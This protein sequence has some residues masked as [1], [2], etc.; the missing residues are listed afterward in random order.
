MIIWTAFR[1]NHSILKKLRIQLSL[2][3][4]VQ[5]RIM[6][7]FG[8]ISRNEDS[9]ERVVVQGLALMAREATVGGRPGGLTQS[10]KLCIQLQ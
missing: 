5:L 3:S 10:L 2:L 6:K 8:R 7:I 9:M 1:T 4:I